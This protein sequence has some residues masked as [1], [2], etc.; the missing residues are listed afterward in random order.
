MYPRKDT[1]LMTEPTMQF[2][3][4]W[5]FANEPMARELD[6]ELHDMPAMKRA[7]AVVHQVW[8]E[9]PLGKDW[10]LAGQLHAQNGVWVIG[11][12]RIF[13]REKLKTRKLGEWSAALRGAS[14]AVPQGG[15]T[16]PLVHTVRLGALRRKIGRTIED[17]RANPGTRAWLDEIGFS[18]AEPRPA[19]EAPDERK[20]GRPRRP[21]VEYARIA[22]YYARRCA[23]ES[24]TP[25]ADTA[26]RFRLTAARV[27]SELW[28]ARERQLLTTTGLKGITGGELT[29]KARTLLQQTKKTKESK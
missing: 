1:I 15:I 10:T 28:V 2:G 29:D 7:L 25:V 3:S 14:A 21:D 11:E 4:D 27:R 6:F 9:T 5:V 23:R 13:P 12:I 8:L 22:D 18:V 16:A 20:R 24:R 19:K 17:W 26:R